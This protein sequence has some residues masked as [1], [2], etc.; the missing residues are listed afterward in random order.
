MLEA[1]DRK[2]AVEV[3]DA[4]APHAVL[5]DVRMPVMDGLEAT[6]RIKSTEQGKETP[7]IAVTGQAFEE[8]RAR[9]LAA[10][11]DDFVRKPFRWEEIFDKI[12]ACLAVEYTYDDGEGGAG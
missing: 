9:V 3:F 10:G 5:M 4:E 12:A 2:E 7:V 8:D 11:A 6:R 1:K